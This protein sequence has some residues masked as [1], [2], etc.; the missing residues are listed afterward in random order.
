M[1]RGADFKRFA[2]GPDAELRRRGLVVIYRVSRC[3]PALWLHSHY[4]ARCCYK[5]QPLEVQARG[6]HG[7]SRPP[8]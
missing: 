1:V 7:A 8:K 5:L 3:L 4:S 2:E 6:R